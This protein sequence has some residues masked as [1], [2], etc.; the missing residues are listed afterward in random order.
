M[1]DCSKN[2]HHKSST[3]VNMILLDVLLSSIENLIQ[4]HFMFEGI[5]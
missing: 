5:W 1:K 4:G 3:L 2:M